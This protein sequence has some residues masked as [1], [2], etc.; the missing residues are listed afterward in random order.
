MHRR[1]GFD[2]L[3]CG[4]IDHDI[5]F[6]QARHGVRFAFADRDN[7]IGIRAALRHVDIRGARRARFIESAAQLVR[8]QTH[9]KILRFGYVFQFPVQRARDAFDRKTDGIALAERKLVSRYRGTVED[10]RTHCDGV[11]FDGVHRVGNDGDELVFRQH[12]FLRVRSDGEHNLKVRHVGLQRVHFQIVERALCFAERIGSVRV[13]HE[14][15]H[16]EA[17]RRFFRFAR[18]LIGRFYGDVRIIE[19][20]VR[21][22]FRFFVR[23]RADSRQRFGRDIRRAVDGV[24]HIIAVNERVVIALRVIGYSQTRHERRRKL[25]VGDRQL[26]DAVVTVRPSEFDAQARRALAFVVIMRGAANGAFGVYRP[27]LII[28]R[29]K[30]NILFQKRIRSVRRIVLPSVISFGAVFDLVARIGEKRTV[31][32]ALASAA[33]KRGKHAL[34]AYAVQQHPAFVPHEHRRALIKTCVVILSARSVGNADNGEIVGFRVAERFCPSLYGDRRALRQSAH[35][36]GRNFHGTSSFHVD[37]PERLYNV[38]AD[39]HFVVFMEIAERER[40][41]RFERRFR[42]RGMADRTGAHARIVFRA[43]IMPD[44]HLHAR[45]NAVG[46]FLR[47]FQNDVITAH[48]SVNDVLAEQH[49]AG[50]ALDRFVFVGALVND[51]HLIIVEFGGKRFRRVAVSKLEYRLSALVDFGNFPL[52]VA[53]AFASGKSGCQNGSKQNEQNHLQFLHNC[54]S[55]P[56]MKF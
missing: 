31:V 29:R 42:L 49:L 46:I 14:A 40:F 5:L 33:R 4:K 2:A 41:G 32:E 34:I 23:R 30:R 18:L 15:V 36:K 55:S 51:V 35:R 16:V 28:R 56:Q 45:I 12:V 13:R 10:H 43:P 38:S 7:D 26:D 47:R 22:I 11:R 37:R 39:K 20:G 19:R 21:K 8:V 25:G 48:R 24:R 6:L 1:I 3:H 50:A 52:R 54:S 27:I 53:L 44:F 17:R 9:R